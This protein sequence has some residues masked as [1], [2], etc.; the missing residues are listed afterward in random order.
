M[1][2]RIY[3]FDRDDTLID[4]NNQLINP[5]FICNFI[6]Q[7]DEAPNH[8]WGIVSAGGSELLADEAYKAISKK[9]QAKEYNHQLRKRP[10]YVTFNG[11]KS[12]CANTTGCSSS[13]ILVSDELHRQRK[14]NEISDEAFRQKRAQMAMH[15]LL[16]DDA[17]LGKLQYLDADK[18]TEVLIHEGSTFTVQLGKTSVVIHAGM[19]HQHLGEIELGA[20][21]LFHVLMA[22]DQA[23]LYVEVSEE[24]KKLGIIA[25]ASPAK[26]KQILP[27]DIIFLDDR[28]ANCN[29]IKNAGFTAID[30]DTDVARDHDDE[31]E[32][33]NT[34]LIKLVKHNPVTPVP[35]ADTR[36]FIQKNPHVR[37]SIIGFSVGMTAIGV[38]ALVFSLAGIAF[39]PFMITLIIGIFT[40]MIITVLANAIGAVCRGISN[41]GN[42]SE[43]QKASENNDETLVWRGDKEYQFSSTDLHKGLSTTPVQTEKESIED[44]SSP[45]LKEAKIIKEE[46]VQSDSESF[47][48]DSEEEESKEDTFR[49]RFSQKTI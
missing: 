34:Y 16:T 30:A 40:P 49:R 14:K 13:V 19:F 41:L 10:A 22:L 18:K 26:Y 39:P 5:G 4:K 27:E 17:V 1:R 25:M 3:L 21:K 7:I 31:D 2:N 11:G 32:Q 44:E 33:H 6:K 47:V 46:R 12:L 35:A 8:D 15:H 36:T 29:L 24:L 38:T 43:D 9:L 28:I 48:S 42:H 23:E 37:D 45:E 20:Y